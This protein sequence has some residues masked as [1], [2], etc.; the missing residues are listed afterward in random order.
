MSKAYVRC[1]EQKA[2][3]TNVTLSGEGG[4]SDGFK[5]RLGATPGE[6]NVRLVAPGCVE[7]QPLCDAT[8]GPQLHPV[9]R[10]VG[11]SGKLYGRAL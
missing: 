10:V 3:P 4:Q 9:L 2:R 6:C 1:L 7:G 11:Q 8:V 5:A